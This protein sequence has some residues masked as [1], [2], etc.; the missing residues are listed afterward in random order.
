MEI[1]HRAC[2]VVGHE[3]ARRHA[4]WGHLARRAAPADGA[5]ISGDAISRAEISGGAISQEEISGGAIS[6]AEIS[7]GAISRAEVERDVQ[8]EA[9]AVKEGRV[10]LLAARHDD[11]E[12]T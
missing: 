4:A 2:V 1:A 7:R 11:R 6:Q 9:F 5:E 3:G 12:A 8:R 10:L